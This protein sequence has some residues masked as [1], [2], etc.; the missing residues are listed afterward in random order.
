MSLTLRISAKAMKGRNKKLL[1]DKQ[2]VRS[3]NILIYCYSSADSF[4]IYI[5]IDIDMCVCYVYV[6]IYTHTPC[7]KSLCLHSIRSC[8]ADTY[9]IR[10]HFL[11]FFAAQAVDSPQ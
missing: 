1:L 4:E 6:Y 9:A 8:Q 2:A 10:L 3:L 7:D 11:D 5:D